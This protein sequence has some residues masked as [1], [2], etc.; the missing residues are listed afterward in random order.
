MPDWV[1]EMF[2]PNKV[3]FAPNKVNF[4]LKKALQRFMGPT[5]RTQMPN[6]EK[7]ITN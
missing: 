6:D 2:H 4:R 3:H 5:P 7:T 1:S